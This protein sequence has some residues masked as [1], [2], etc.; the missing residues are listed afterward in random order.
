MSGGIERLALDLEN[1]LRSNDESAVSD[2]KEILAQMNIEM[3]N[4]DAQSR[5]VW[6]VKV[7]EY[8]RQIN[9]MQRKALLGID[10][11]DSAA[12]PF[13]YAQDGNGQEVLEK[14]KH[15]ILTSGDRQKKMLEDSYKQLLESETVATGTMTELAIQ[16]QKLQ[17]ITAHVE[18]VNGDLGIANRLLNKMNAWWR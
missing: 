16:R 8:E 15:E 4:V 1:I 10:A 2:A 13:N 6:K 9:D 14:A 7:K 17:K 3:F 18:D 12:K 11:K 5:K